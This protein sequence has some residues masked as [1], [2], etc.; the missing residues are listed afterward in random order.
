M[1]A[2]FFLPN[3]GG[4]GTERVAINLAKE[5]RR[6]GVAVKFV[7]LEDRI[8]LDVD[9]GHVVLIGVGKSRTTLMRPL[10]WVGSIMGLR[11]VLEAEAP[12]ALVSFL[13]GPNYMASIARCFSRIPR[14][15][16]SERCV[17]STDLGGWIWRLVQISIWLV[18]RSADTIIVN[19]EE[20]GRDLQK[21]GVRSEKIVRV[22]NPADLEQIQSLGAAPIAE[23][24]RLYSRPAI[25]AVGRLEE[26]KGYPYL[27][28]AFEMLDNR[29]IHL[30]ILGKGEDEAKLKR[31]AVDLRVED[32]VF[33]V[34]FQTNPYRFIKH[35]S[36]LVLSSLWEGQPNVL[37]EALALGTPIVATDC[38][39]SIREVLGKGEFGV[40]IPSG[41]ARLLSDAIGDVLEGRARFDREALV[42]RASEFAM[43]KIGTRYGE[44]VFGPSSVG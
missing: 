4:G 6:R 35:A 5:F 38:S 12:D 33:F 28:R 36:L 7:I 2:L 24:D 21:L 37:I 18:Y 20:I 29:D 14:L 13:T 15:V 30:I 16:L 1:K 25:C 34:G 39:S 40:I 3:L 31:L 44:V 8:E 17:V 26:E 42:S 19:S 10:Y 9:R 23:W 11:R 41:D 22:P 27:L 43:E 32:R